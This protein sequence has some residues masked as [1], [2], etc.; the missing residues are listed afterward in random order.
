MIL[1]NDTERPNEEWM[2]L[3]DR[4][5][6]RELSVILSNIDFVKWYR[7]AEYWFVKIGGK[8]ISYSFPNKMRAAP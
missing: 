3:L 6:G 7:E 4:F 5:I 1:Q 2:C 8:S